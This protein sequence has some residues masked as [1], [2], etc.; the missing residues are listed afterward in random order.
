MMVIWRFL[1]KPAIINGLQ[2]SLDSREKS[3]EVKIRILADFV[4][5]VLVVQHKPGPW[6]IK[7]VENF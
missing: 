7:E 1:Y 6:Q 3:W 5:T 4:R 2:F